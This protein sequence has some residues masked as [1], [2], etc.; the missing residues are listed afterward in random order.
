MRRHPAL[1][2][3][4]G[5]SAGQRP[6]AAPAELKLPAPALEEHHELRGD[7]AG[8]LRAEVLLDQR[9]GQVEPRGDPGCG[10]EGTVEDADRIGIDR[11][12][13]IAFGERVRHGPMGRDPSTLQEARLPE[14]ERSAADR[15]VAPAAGRGRG[16]PAAQGL[17]R[18]Q[19][20]QVRRARDQKGVEGGRTIRLHDAVGEQ[21]ATGRRLDRPRT[22][23]H[24]GQR[25]DRRARLH[26]RLREDIEWAGDV[27]ELHSRHCEHRN[28]ARHRH[29]PV[30]PFA[31][32][33]WQ[34]TPDDDD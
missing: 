7:L 34:K 23:P 33:R 4:E 26:V 15:A 2:F 32:G 29:T 16:E 25:V 10:P 30:C 1:G 9:E 19:S 22:E 24:D 27:E 17:V 12:L 13:G 11:G 28:A 5:R 8:D 21:A 6:D 20:V 3:L 31:P 18:L 14:Q